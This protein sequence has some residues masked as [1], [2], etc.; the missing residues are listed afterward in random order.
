MR[1]ERGE[2]WMDTVY[3]GKERTMINRSLWYMV[4]LSSHS[5][6][7][8]GVREDYWG[9]QRVGRI[10]VPRVLGTINRCVSVHYGQA[11]NT[12]VNS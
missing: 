12:K 11:H 10:A 4:H 5:T 2:T 3:D 1:K 9:I 7:P 8:D 6:L